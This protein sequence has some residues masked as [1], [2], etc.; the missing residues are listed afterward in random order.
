MSLPWDPP[1]KTLRTDQPEILGTWIASREEAVEEV[2][3]LWQPGKFLLALALTPVDPLGNR[4][5]FVAWLV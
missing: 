1:P 5:L 4:H 3:L 2:Q